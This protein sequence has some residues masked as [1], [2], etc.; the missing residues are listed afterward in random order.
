MVT[1]LLLVTVVVA[2]VNVALTLPAAT[3]TLAGSLAADELSFKDTTAPPL[4]AGA[5]NVTVPTDVDPPLTLAGLK[6]RELSVGR[7]SGV[8]VSVTVAALLLCTPSFA[9]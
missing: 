1:V 9:L 4:A 6:V 2:I 8:T 5:L 7:T 3:V